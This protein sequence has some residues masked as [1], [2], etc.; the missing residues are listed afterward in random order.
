MYRTATDLED[1]K[2][3]EAER[4]RRRAVQRVDVRQRRQRRHCRRTAAVAEQR[5]GRGRRELEAE[6]TEHGEQ[7]T[8]HCSTLHGIA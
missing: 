1:G 4:A 3:D 2:D 5:R 8:L 6:L 7:A